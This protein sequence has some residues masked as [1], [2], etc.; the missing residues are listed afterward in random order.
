MLA[1]PYLLPSGRVF[2][3]TGSQAAK[4]VVVVLFAGG[5]RQQ[6]SVL[7]RYLADSQNLDIEGNVMLNLLAGAVPDDKVVF[8]TS[9][10]GSL[11]I[12]VILPTPLATLGT[13]LPEM[14]YSASATGHYSGLST[15]LSGHYGSFQGLQER[16]LHPTMF[17]YLRRHAGLK[18]TDTW[19]VGNGLT[20][21]V[22]LLNHSN[23]PAY[24]AAYG[25][26]MIIPNVTFGAPGQAHVRG[27]RVFHPEEELPAIQQMRAFLNQRFGAPGASDSPLDAL[28]NTEEEKINIKRFVAE[29]FAR[30]DAGAIALPPVNDNGDLMTIAFACEV[31]RYFKPKLTVVNLSSADSCHNS[32]TNYLKALHRADHG[33]GFLWSYLQNELPEIAADTAIVL[34]P[35]HGRNLQP[36]N[37]LDVNNWR[38]FD[39]DSDANARRIFGMMAGAGVPAN[40]R[41]GSE[42]RPIGDAADTVLTV[43][44]LL[45]IKPDVQAAGLISP[46]AQSWFDRI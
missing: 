26:N 22:P 15:A 27:S 18:A 25:A 9:A 16:P 35:E 19:F 10:A 24:G 33:V 1:A 2:A 36:N 13:L 21:S 38:A 23:H 17:E 46:V 34:V 43:A 4:H 42:S 6:E 5:V 29:T 14:R 41:V 40:V 39:H 45:G 37:V 3:Q 20:G 32:Y 7:Q 31:M 28:G 11:P 30:I 8:G 44:E 12:P